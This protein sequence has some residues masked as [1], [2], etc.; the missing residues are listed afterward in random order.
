MHLQPWWEPQYLIPMLGMVLGN[1]ISGVSVGLS[2]VLEELTAG[3][4]RSKRCCPASAAPAA[5]GA[6]QG[7]AAPA[8][9]EPRSAAPLLA[10]AL[11]PSGRLARAPHP[12][13]MGAMPAR[14]QR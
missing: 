11:L 10:R 7:R 9:A 2:T 12:P 14:A 1:T 4:G 8:A 13:P 3:A 5:R 6:G